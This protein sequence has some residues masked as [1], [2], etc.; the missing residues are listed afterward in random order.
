MVGRG[1]GE[2]ELRA[3]DAVEAEVTAIDVVA[4]QDEERVGDVLRILAVRVDA[5]ERR[6][7]STVALRML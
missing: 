6:L 5:L 2:L 1:D 7:W 3:E 4:E